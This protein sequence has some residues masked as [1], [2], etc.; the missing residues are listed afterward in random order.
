MEFTTPDYA[1]DG[2]ADRHCVWMVL[3]LSSQCPE[4]VRE[5]DCGGGSDR[6]CNQEIVEHVG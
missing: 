1:D 4:T 3:V 2:R 6:H 5:V